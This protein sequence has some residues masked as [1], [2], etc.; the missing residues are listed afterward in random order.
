MSHVPNNLSAQEFS[1]EQMH[2]IRALAKQCKALEQHLA[3]LEGTKH[4]QHVITK[5]QVTTLV[6]YPEL[7]EAYPAISITN[8]YQAKLPKD[9]DVFEW[10]NIHYTKDVD[11][12]APPVVEHT[13]EVVL[14]APA[15]KH[16]NDL[17]SIQSTMAGS[18]HFLDTFVHEIVSSG[19]TESNLGQRTLNF[20]NTICLIKKVYY[21]A[22]NIKHGNK[23]DNLLLTL[24]ELT[25][26]K[27]AAEQVRK[28]YK[29]YEPKK[30]KPKKDKPSNA[31]AS[32]KPK[33]QQQ[34]KPQHKD[35][36]YKSDGGHKSDSNKSFGKQKPKRFQKK[37]PL[38]GIEQEESD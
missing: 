35:K 4:D 36:G 5:S 11:Y 29:K 32:N 1:P 20:L 16:E 22:L 38:K 33:T 37:Q 25:T 10:N 2:Q 6:P 27:T 8:L 18:T 34:N 24:K 30:E 13:A 26:I 21:D 17:S 28:V 9:H 7:L 12:K 15:K 3:E 31:G 19:N 23:K 14:S